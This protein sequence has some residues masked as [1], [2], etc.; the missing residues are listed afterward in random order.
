MILSSPMQSHVTMR[1]YF[2]LLLV[3][4]GSSLVHAQAPA[5]ASEQHDVTMQN[6][7]ESYARHHRGRSRCTRRT[8]EPERP[9]RSIRTYRSTPHP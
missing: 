8:S 6:V 2:A 5:P 1:N 7:M 4:I 3:V 9:S